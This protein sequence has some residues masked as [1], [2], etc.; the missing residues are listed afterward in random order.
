MLQVQ[1]KLPTLIQEISV[2][3]CRVTP[4]VQA[5]EALPIGS[6]DPNMISK[7]S[8][9]EVRKEKKIDDYPRPLAVVGASML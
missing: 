8:D 7:A 5:G 4:K 3:G 2:I 1:D 9:R 6:Q